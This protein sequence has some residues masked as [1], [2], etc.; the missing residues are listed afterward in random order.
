MEGLADQELV[1]A[2]Q[3]GDE[4]AYAVLVSRHARGILALSMGLL[5]RVDDAEDAT[6]EALLR[7]LARIDQLREPEQ[8]RVWIMGIARNVCIDLLRRRKRTRGALAGVRHQGRSDPADHA[9]LERALEQLAEKYRLPLML[10]YFD[11]R[12]TE[13]IAEALG[14]TN[15]GVRTRL[16]RARRELRGLL[17]KDMGA[18]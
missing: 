7:G 10:Y 16:S 18:K 14:L 4:R 12:S 9:E 17:D 15:A 13:R 1:A 2:C 3:R 5:G 6:Q 11:G 8:F